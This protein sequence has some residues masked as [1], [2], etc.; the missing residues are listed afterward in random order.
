[1]T[2]SAAAITLAIAV[3]DHSK[4]SETFVRRHIDQL[5]GGRTVVVALSGAAEAGETRPLL[6][7]GP[8]PKAERLSDPRH[9]LRMA[10]AHLRMALP[11]RQVRG[12]LRRTGATHALCEFG[13]VAT[14]L[15]PMLMASGLPVFC[16]F[17]G[18]DASAQLRNPAYV[19]QLRTLFPR[20]AGIFAVSRFLLDNLA[21]A[22]LVH[23]NA[24]VIPSGTDVQAFRPE[25]GPPGPLLSVGRFVAKKS[26]VQLFQA[27]ALLGDLP[28]LRLELVGDG[29]GL[30]EA[31]RAAN[32]LGL[33]G[34]VHFAGRLPHD[35]VRARMGR[36]LAYVQH[37]DTSPT[38]DTEGMP[39][40]IQEA[41]AAGRAIVTTRHAGIPEHIRDGE[42]GLLC[43]PGD[44]PALAAALRRVV[45]EAALRDRLGQ[46]ARAHAVAELDYRLL[47]RRTEAVI[48]GTG[49]R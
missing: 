44:V 49:R 28:E 4:F 40:V 5:F 36:A 26:P 17:R 3:R 16:Y 24:H 32:D 13:Y 14:A 31:R 1:M 10:G 6:V 2:D 48:A 22:G 9:P 8:V 45:T 11:G 35:E 39:S 23:P 12:F 37:F 46:A 25:P 21:Q 29:P 18:N 41:M 27:L 42:T 20:L 7:T 34:R 15:A 43:E 38:G 33:T 47:Y 30:D 19:A